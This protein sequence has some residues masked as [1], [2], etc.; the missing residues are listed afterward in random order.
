MVS[1][2]WDHAGKPAASATMASNAVR[3]KF[4]IGILISLALKIF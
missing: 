3:A 4:A 1:A 2:F